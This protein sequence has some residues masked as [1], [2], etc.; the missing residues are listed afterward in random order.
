MP[1]THMVGVSHE[2]FPLVPFR[3][4]LKLCSSHQ[5]AKQMFAHVIP[6][7]LVARNR[8]AQN[9]QRRVEKITAVKG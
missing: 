6:V 3:Y 5:Y 2:K 9:R 1:P 8:I 7:R 4:R